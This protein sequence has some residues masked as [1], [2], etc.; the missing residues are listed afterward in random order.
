MTV[1]DILGNK[2]KICLSNAEVLN[3]FGNYEGL[4]SMNDSIK[5][6]FKELLNEVL[7]SRGLKYNDKMLIQIKASVNNGCVIIISPSNHRNRIENQYQYIFTNTEELTNGILYLYKLKPNIKSD[8]YKS[9]F[10]YRL[11]IY[12]KDYS[13]YLLSLNE[14]AKKESHNIIEVAFTKEYCKPLVT[15]NAVRTYGKA[16]FKGI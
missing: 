7:L 3:C 10:D 8:I 1:S 14:F 4:Y 13:K 16:F 11:I 2:I 5:T 9:D 6:A 15:K 12:S